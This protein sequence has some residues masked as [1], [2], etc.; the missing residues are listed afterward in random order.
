M[1]I[2]TATDIVFLTTIQ[3]SA[4]VGKDCWDRARDQ[5]V[6]TSIY[7]HLSPSF[8]NKAG[9]SDDV[10]DSVHYG[11]LINAI[12]SL[13][14]AR[15]EAYPDV[16]TLI[17]QVTEAAFSLAGDHADAVRIVVELPKQI[18]LADGFVVE[19]TTPKG[20]SSRLSPAI[21]TVKDL[22]L[23]VLIGVNPPE[24]LAKQR[25]ITNIT[26]YEKAGGAGTVDY[27]TLIKKIATD[28]DQ[29]DYETLEK[30]VLK[31]VQSGCSA[32]EDIEAVT[33]KSQKPSAVSFAHSSGVEITRRRNSFV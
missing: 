8:L 7:L 6:L 18:L 20:A 15:Q 30:F 26:F 12:T 22:V 17:E 2:P 9:E 33:A 13:V 11:H 32:S 16:R 29:T 4:S 3:L 24:R 28:I 14:S 31:I 21:V 23:P 10:Q 25:V 27:P 1:S 5:I 19:V